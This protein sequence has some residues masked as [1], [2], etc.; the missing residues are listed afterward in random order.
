MFL[1]DYT[2][3][4]CPRVE[5]RSISWLN[6]VS[7]Y[8]PLNLSRTRRISHRASPWS[9]GSIL[10]PKSSQPLDNWEWIVLSTFSLEET[11]LQHILLWSYMPREM[12]FWQMTNTQS[13]PFWDR[14]RLMEHPPRMRMMKD[15]LAVLSKRSTLS[16][17][18]LIWL[19]IVSPL[20]Q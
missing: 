8:T 17:L 7:G 5:L 9:W 11:N 10:G 16:V 12:L 1:E 3:L 19:R 2:C 18:Q 13:Y 4:R 15:Q 6:Q 20:T 14:T